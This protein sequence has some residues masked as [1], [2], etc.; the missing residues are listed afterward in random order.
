VIQ[1]VQN[2]GSLSFAR[3]KALPSPIEQVSGDHAG[4]EGTP[5]KLELQTLGMRQINLSPMMY[6][7]RVNVTGCGVRLSRTGPVE[8]LIEVKG[9]AEKRD[10]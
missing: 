10:P 9:R 8:V 4:Q 6:E 5:P 1:A 7:L 3:R 2:C